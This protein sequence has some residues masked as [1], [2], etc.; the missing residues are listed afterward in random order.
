MNT[1]NIKSVYSFAARLSSL[2]TI[3]FAIVL[4]TSCENESINEHII[5]KNGDGINITG[6]TVTVPINTVHQ[7]LIDVVSER[8]A[9]YLRQYDFGEIE[10]LE[11]SKDFRVISHDI[12]SEKSV[13]TTSFADTLVHAGSVVKITVR[14]HTDMVKSAYYKVT[15]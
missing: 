15:Q 10:E 2:L 8:S 4:F 14:I 9:T 13:I 1:L 3:I 11:N 6:D 12:N 7:T 5:I